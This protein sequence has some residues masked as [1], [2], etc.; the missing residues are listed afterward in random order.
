MV[1]KK[2]PKKTY[3][4]KGQSGNPHGRPKKLYYEM[5]D[6]IIKLINV[7]HK[8]KTNDNKSQKKLEIIKEILNEK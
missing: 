5:T 2:P 4:K 1:Y 3:F 7:I 6:T 8:S